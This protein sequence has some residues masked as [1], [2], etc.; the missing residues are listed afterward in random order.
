MS[1]PT[2]KIL[3][4]SVDTDNDI[5]R[6][7]GLSTPI[8]GRDR[9]ASAANLFATKTP[10]DSD[11]NAVFAAMN[12]YDSLQDQGFICEVALIA[13]KEEGGFES[14]LKITSDLDSILSQ[15]KADGVIFVSDGA[16]DEQVIPTIVS[17]IPIISVRRVFVQQEKS[18]EETYVLLARYFKKLGEPQYARLALGIPGLMILATI[19]LYY[20]D[21]LNYAI[22]TVGIIIG[23]VLIV[24]GFAVDRFVKDAWGSSPIKLISAIIATLIC[25][26]S[27]YRG[28]SIALTL[29]PPAESVATF[30]SAVLIN[31]IDLFT[32]G[33][34]IYIMGSL[35]VKYLD[36]SPKLWHEIVGV[37]ALIFIRQ[38]VI[39]VA[40]IIE[41]PQGNIL[42]FLFTAGLGAIVCAI[43]VVIFTLTPRVRKK[44]TGRPSVK[45]LQENQL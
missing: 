34:A 20:Y 36:D 42:P 2:K 37:V 33:I 44:V 11:V 12:T 31:T 8:I 1:Q 41:N 14:D 38:M 19:V 21:L 10:E 23:A 15:F 18:V 28:I 13:G 4:L 3:I 5:G 35:V 7:T 30:L 25:S 26:V 45:P 43:L 6:A 32:L 39:D 16:S 40:P 24:K 17:K 22:L 27:L 9:V 29:A